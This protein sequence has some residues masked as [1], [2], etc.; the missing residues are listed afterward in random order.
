MTQN[1]LRAAGL[2]RTMMSMMMMMAAITTNKHGL[3]ATTNTAL[4]C[5]A[6]WSYVGFRFCAID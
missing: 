4:A 3:L 1:E 5:V 6:D 2:T